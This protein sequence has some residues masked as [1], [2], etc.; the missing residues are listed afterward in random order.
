MDLVPHN[1]YPF[2]K[3]IKQT[4]KGQANMVLHLPFF[5]LSPTF[6]WFVVDWFFWGPTLLV[7]FNFHNFFFHLALLLLFFSLLTYMKHEL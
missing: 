1:Q 5:S 7:Y 3:F 4:E 2:C 6:L